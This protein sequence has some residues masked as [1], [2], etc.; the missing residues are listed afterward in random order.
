MKR[1]II[2]LYLHLCVR[3]GVVKGEPW[4]TGLRKL[5]NFTLLAEF[6]PVILLNC[7]ND[8]E[9]GDGH[10]DKIPGGKFGKNLVT[11][12]LRSCTQAFYKYNNNINIM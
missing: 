7:R 4:H 3:F 10:S 9:D 2:R 6:S 11:E 8:L 1:H 12:Q 5:R